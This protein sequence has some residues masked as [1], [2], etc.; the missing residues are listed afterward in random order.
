MIRA[1]RRPASSRLPTGRRARSWRLC[2]RFSPFLRWRP[3]MSASRRH[4]PNGRQSSGS[5]IRTACTRPRGIVS[6]VVSSSP[7]R[8]R[9]PSEASATVRLYSPF[10]RRQKAVSRPKMPAVLGPITAMRGA[11]KTSSATTISTPS[12]S[13][14][15]PEPGQQDRADQA[16]RRHRH[17]HRL[18]PLGRGRCRL[19]AAVGERE[20]LGPQALR[21]AHG[22]VG[23]PAGAARRAHPQPQL[24][25][26]EDARQ[27][28]AEPCRSPESAGAETATSSRRSRPGLDPQV[29]ALDAPA[30]DEPRDHAERDD[31]RRRRRDRPV[32][33]ASRRPESRR[34]ERRRRR[35]RAAPGRRGRPARADAAGARRPRRPA[36][37]SPRSQ[38][39]GLRLSQRRELVAQP[40]RVSRARAPGCGRRWPRRPCAFA[41][42][43]ART[44]A[45]PARPSRRRTASGR[46]GRRRAA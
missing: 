14:V 28:R 45:R 10:T 1:R 40:R 8:R 26:P 12:A 36:R 9:N 11:G 41:R 39:G 34:W 21:L 4:Q 5:V 30:S 7:A 31:R 16:A 35:A 23:E 43:R 46:R 15:K 33:G 37:P 42:S 13:T 19:L 27:H 24:G 44:T 6:A 17:E 25:Q 38:A 18:L 22:H 3:A 20:Q 29:A 2:A 32:P